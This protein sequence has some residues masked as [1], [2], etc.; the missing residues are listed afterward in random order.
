MPSERDN[1][2]VKFDPSV[3]DQLACPA[4]LGPLSLQ[5]DKLACVACGHTYPI[6]DSIPVLIAVSTK[7]SCEGEE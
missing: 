3:L 5:E 6:V 7:T 4:C 2:S 1:P